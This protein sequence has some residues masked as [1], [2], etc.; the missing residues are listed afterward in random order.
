MF[1]DLQ[2][3]FGA[4]RPQDRVADPRTSVQG[5]PER[6]GRPERQGRSGRQGAPRTAPR[7]T[8]RP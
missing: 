6:R 4:E 5:R 7:R 1:A 3:G 2:H 8:S